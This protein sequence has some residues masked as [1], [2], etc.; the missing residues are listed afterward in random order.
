M[1]DR[2]LTAIAL[3]AATVAFAPVANAAEHHRNHG[4]HSSNGW[5]RSH[6]RGGNA[7][8][9]IIGGV[10][11]L[12]LGAAIAGSSQP[13]YAPP[14]YPAPGYYYPPQTYYYPPQAYYA[15]VPSYPPGAGGDTTSDLNRQELYRLQTAPY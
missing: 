1:V 7:G 10:I 11:G 9:A 5:N 4:Q 13:Y 14:Y 15:P 3:I 6:H 12:G 2:R 8:A